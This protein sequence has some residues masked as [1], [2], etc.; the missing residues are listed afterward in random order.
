MKDALERFVLRLLSR[1]DFYALYPSRVVAQRATSIDLVPDDPRMPACRA[2]L[3]P[4]LPGMTITV[5]P[6]S[7]VLLGF[8]NG[9]P[10]R[11]IATLWEPGA[12]VTKLVFGGAGDARPIARQGDPVAVA[13]PAAIQVQGTVNGST[14]F[15][16]VITIATPLAGVI[17]GGS[18]KVQVAS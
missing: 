16:G 13:L 7:R 14:P 1:F 5:T 3:R 17:A 12:A 8:E 18:G 6:G 11:P 10:R 2:E 4:G 15:V 9:D